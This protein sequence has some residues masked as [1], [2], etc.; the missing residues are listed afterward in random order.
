MKHATSFPSMKKFFTV[1]LLILI[2]LVLQ[3]AKASPAPTPDPAAV[4]AKTVADL[5]AWAALKAG[6]GPQGRPL[7][8]AASWMVGESPYTDLYLRGMKPGDPDQKSFVLPLDS[9]PSPWR[10]VE[11]IKQGHHVLISFVDII[12]TK[13]MRVPPG[14]L[15][16]DEKFAAYFDAYYRPALEYARANKLPIAFR[17]WNWAKILLDIENGVRGRLPEGSDTAKL[18]R[19]GVPNNSLA[20]PFGPVTRWEE[21][22]KIWMGHEL[23]QKIQE[24]YPD[25]PMVIFLNNHEAG[26]INSPSQIDDTCDR[27]VALHGTGKDLDF[28][29]RKI[30][31]GYAERYAALFA[32]A[33]AA[34]VEPG[35]R[36]NS[37]F[38]AYNN[39]SSP[40]L[41][42]GVSDTHDWSGRIGFDPESG[43]TEHRMY[44]GGMP[45]YYDNH[46]QAPLKGDWSPWSPQAEASNLI[47]YQDA[48]V[49]QENPTFYW[50]S[51]VWGGDMPSQDL[52]GRPG[53]YLTDD[54]SPKAR[55]D[56]DRYT[57]MLQFGLWMLRPRDY[58]EFRANNDYRGFQGLTWE[59]L[60]QSVDRV[61]NNPTLTE[62]WKF[63]ELVHNPV[64]GERKHYFSSAA[65][66]PPWMKNM[67]RWFLLTSDA[68]PP[69]SEWPVYS[70]I[71]N[72]DAL[73]VFAMALQLGKSPERRWLIYAHAPLGAVAGSHVTLP[74]KGSVA[75][76]YVS[77]SGSFFVVDEASGKVEPLH[78]GG[79]A[80][81]ALE[82]DH[83]HVK[84][85]SP[86]VVKANVRHPATTPFE[87]FTWKAP[88]QPER[89]TREPGSETFSFSKAGEYMITL[90]ATTAAGEKVVGQTPVWVRNTLPAADTVIDLPLTCTYAWEGPW[91]T[92][93]PSGELMTFRY[94][95]NASVSFDREPVLLGGRFVEDPERGSVLEL[96][97]EKEGVIIT[98]SKRTTM[99][100]K[101]HSDLAIDFW[102]KAEDVQRRQQLFSQGMDQRP[103]INIY[104]EDGKLFAGSWVQ[105]PPTVDFP[106][107]WI[108]SPVVAGKW[109]HVRFVLNDA[110]TNPK[111]GVATLFLDGKAVGSA[112]AAMLPYAYGNPRLSL[113]IVAGAARTASGKKMAK[114]DFFKGRFSNFTYSTGAAARAET[115][116][117]EAGGDSTSIQ[118]TKVVAAINVGGD[119]VAGTSGISYQADTGGEGGSVQSLLATIP[120]QALEDQDVYR[121]FRV[122][123]AFSYQF[124]L[125]NGNYLV[126]L[127]F[128]E[129]EHGSTPR[130]FHV[131][132]QGQR[133]TQNLNIEKTVGVLNE[134]E[135]KFP[136]RIVDGRL[137]MNFEATSGEALL[138]GLIIEKTTEH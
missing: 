47:A 135:L 88:G 94:L 68:N 115:G 25:P 108:S 57:G 129:P 48:K 37:L 106:G 134:L 137:S 122:G 17:G 91:G 125:P 2:S 73:R 23:M 54:Q 82:P 114:E 96:E 100:P 63:G 40:T 123:T 102:F 59:A 33:R 14:Q 61:W 117:S 120:L 75:L 34:F 56:I 99:E 74:G 97:G 131:D 36:K 80:E 13:G 44:D 119:A 1:G 110:E 128:I 95:P 66:M 64:F 98:R 90:E 69:E 104:L 126:R 107:D 101:G 111:P 38:V 31:E 112:S 39:T 89:N 12:G 15:L 105:V 67:D 51:I 7:P 124:Y 11:E 32:A 109:V 10:L 138:A 43:Y 93:L 87:R 49:W 18:I 132:L 8:L 118:E 136:A 42:R 30:R 28:R 86:V 71:A 6:N 72:D 133:V 29:A 46:W 70:K 76:D 4:E 5:Q 60:L 84:P 62:F 65:S 116:S 127:K 19:N 3:A 20:D 22:G 9:G 55:W 50:S 45:E 52:V 85:G 81:L 83:R 103:G 79:P 21:F 78:R 27:F 35:W 16:S 77:S 26:Q 121:S 92:E 130:Q 113:P 24:F 58:H 41:G 53:R